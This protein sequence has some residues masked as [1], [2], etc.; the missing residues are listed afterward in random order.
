MPMKGD[1]ALSEKTNNTKP[2]FYTSMFHDKDIDFLHVSL[3]TLTANKIRTLHF[4]RVIEIGKCIKGSGICYLNDEAIPF[5]EGD[6]Q[7]IRPYEPHYNIYNTPGTLWYFITIDIRKINSQHFPVPL[8][9]LSD[10]I[11]NQIKSGIYD[12]AEYPK[13]DQTITNLIELYNTNDGNSYHMESLVL[14]IYSL[15]LDSSRLGKNAAPNPSKAGSQI[16]KI[17]PALKLVSISIKQGKVLSIEEMASA[18]NMS[19]SHF[20]KIF[21]E[22]MNET[23]KSYFDRLQMEKAAEIILTTDLPL[24]EIAYKIGIEESSTFYRKFTKYY[25]QSPIEFK[26]QNL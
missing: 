20:R 18:C 2:T 7:I 26:K 9:F 17:L 16:T 25:G 21:L 1:F 19:Q 12:P 15:L 3:Y 6:I 14:Q 11:Q 5:S 4:H 10:L 23:P 22:I 24:S 13:I 8:V